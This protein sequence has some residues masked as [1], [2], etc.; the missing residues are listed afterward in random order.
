MVP[1]DCGGALGGADVG[2]DVR[3]QLPGV[4]AGVADGAGKD[5]RPC[6]PMPSSAFGSIPRRRQRIPH[7]QGDHFERPLAEPEQ[8][9][10]VR[11]A[12]PCRSEHDG[13]GS[14]LAG[15]LRRGGKSIRGFVLR[16]NHCSGS[17]ASLD[18][19]A[20]AESE[21]G[22]Y[23]ADLFGGIG[24]AARAAQRRDVHGRVWDFSFGSRFRS[25]QEFCSRDLSSQCEERRCIR[26]NA[27]SALWHIFNCPERKIRSA[28]HPWSMPGISAHYE[29]KAQA[30][31][32][33][34]KCAITFARALAASG[35]SWILEHL[36]TKYIFKSSEIQ[37]LI[38]H[39]QAV[40]VIID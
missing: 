33:I 26:S 8:R 23:L 38:K 30:G 40:L 29:A 34:L 22:C 31:H 12:Q 15:F 1:G 7:S 19:R 39:S 37:N 13:S 32:R 17:R 11:K 25:E 2:A 10:A 16:P 14:Q 21:K 36:Q 35:T 3:L 20:S 6:C 9:P 28:A 4:L 24:G 18:P 5:A 27:G